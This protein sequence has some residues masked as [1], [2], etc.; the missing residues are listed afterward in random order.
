M[1]G[2][3]IGY[4]WLYRALPVHSRSIIGTA[5]YE[6]GL[7]PLEG[8]ASTERIV[9]LGLMFGALATI[10]R[11][12]EYCKSVISNSVV[13]FDGITTEQGVQLTSIDEWGRELALLDIYMKRVV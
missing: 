9:H 6:K 5:I 12:P 2:L 11:A 4:D 7:K 13:A 1:M 3:A 10:E 8:V